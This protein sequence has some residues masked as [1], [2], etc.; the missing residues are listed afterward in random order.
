MMRDWVEW[1]IGEA[2]IIEQELRDA[3]N[4][5]NCLSRNKVFVCLICREEKSCNE[6]WTIG[7][8]CIPCAAW[9]IA[10][11]RAEIIFKEHMAEARAQAWQKELSEFRDKNSKYVASIERVFAEICAKGQYTPAA[12]IKKYHEKFGG[13][14][15]VKNASKYQD[16]QYYLENNWR[17]EILK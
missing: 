2:P 11:A 10:H 12:T 9:R 15:S 16:F 5:K 4:A 6:F 8:E 3:R 1:V 13:T 17:K 7:E 14:P